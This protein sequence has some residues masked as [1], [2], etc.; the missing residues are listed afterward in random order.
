MNPIIIS[1]RI[2]T[3]FLYG[4]GKYDLLTYVVLRKLILNGL[5]PSDVSESS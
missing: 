3:Y 1:K 5:Y 2:N 4:L